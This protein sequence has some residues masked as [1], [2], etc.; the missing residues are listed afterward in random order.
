[1]ITGQLCK[2]FI[3]TAGGQPWIAL[4]GSSA[5]DM[6]KATLKTNKGDIHLELFK[7]AAPRTVAN[8][9]GLAEG[10][11]EFTDPK[12]REKTNERAK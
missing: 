12:T 6:I 11:K 8:F 10:P 3:N 4:R 2:K 1:M 5:M 7:N 9:I